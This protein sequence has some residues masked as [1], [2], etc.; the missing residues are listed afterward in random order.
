MY[1]KRIFYPVG[2]GGFSEEVFFSTS[3]KELSVV[4]DCGC[5]NENYGN[6]SLDLRDSI[7]NWLGIEDSIDL[8]FIS[9]YHDDHVNLLY[10]L[11]SRYDIK[12]II[13]PE[14]SSLESL[15]YLLDIFLKDK[16]KT[17]QRERFVFYEELLRRELD[18]TNVHFYSP[19][20]DFN[21]YDKTRGHLKIK[22]RNI[23]IK[24]LDKKKNEVFSNGDQFNYARIWRFIPYYRKVEMVDRVIINE[25]NK[26]YSELIDEEDNR[27]DITLLEGN[28][29]DIMEIFENLKDK[30]IE[31]EYKDRFNPH[32]SNLTLYSGPVAA[33]QMKNTSDC[34]YTGDY[35]NSEEYID[36]LIDF[37]RNKSVFME[38]SREDSRHNYIVWAHHGDLDYYNEELYKRF[39]SYIIFSNLLKKHI[40]ANI[41]WVNEIDFYQKQYYL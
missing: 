27:I 2:H 35:Y 5:S 20:N 25:L 12:N 30:E 23:D 4:Y 7:Y 32:K 16:S 15:Y 36:S 38:T 26:Y 40:K 39:G 10:E 3:G 19:E 28:F 11:S 8:L 17:F 6:K 14:I 21:I 34:L 29:R 13:L 31:D 18:G 9:H 24:K 33:G 37:Y 1:M 22:N 41:H